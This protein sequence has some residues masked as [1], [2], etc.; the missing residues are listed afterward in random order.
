[1][2]LHINENGCQDK[3]VLILDT[4]LP[5]FYVKVKELFQ[6]EPEEVN[7]ILVKNKVEFTKITGEENEDCCTYSDGNVIYIY[8]PNQFGV[9]TSVPRENFYEALCS[10]LVNLFYKQNQTKININ[11]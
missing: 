4:R 8:E 2:K 9:A 5:Y 10:E 6:K 11:S 3:E 7:I 1:M